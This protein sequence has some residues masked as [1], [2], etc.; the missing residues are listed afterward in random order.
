MRGGGHGLLS[1]GSANLAD[2]RKG[3]QL[4]RRFSD[5]PARPDEDHLSRGTPAARLNARWAAAA[6]NAAPQ[7]C[8]PHSFRKA[9]TLRRN[10]SCA[11][12]GGLARSARPPSL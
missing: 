4:V 7:S 1:K 2:F 10:W 8:L 12:D 11:V 3:A 9:S 5:L 6:S